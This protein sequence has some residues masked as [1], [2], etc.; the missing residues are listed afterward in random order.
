MRRAALLI[1]VALVSTLCAAQ[2]P[3]VRVRLLTQYRLSQI[4]ITPETNSTLTAGANSTTRLRA[5]VI[6]RARNNAVEMSGRVN[7]MVVVGG[8]FTLAS[9]PARSQTLHVP[10]E[11][12]ARAGSLQAVA[13]FPVEDYVASVLQGETAADMPPEALKALA[14][15]IRSYA[16]HF[17]GRHES[18]G[19]DFCDTT[20]CQYLRTEVAAR[21]RAAV[22]QTSGQLLWDRGTPLAAYYHKDCG[23]RTEA[24]GVAWPDQASAELSSQRDP[25]CIRT[26]AQWRAELSRADIERALTGAGLTVP[27][28]WTRIAVSDR[29]PSGRA[30]LLRFGSGSTQAGVP[31]SASS[32]RFALGRTL[33]WNMLKSD[34]YDV[35][36]SGDRFV[37]SGRGV[38]HGV[39]L[40]QTGASEMAREGRTYREILAFYYAGA[41]LGRSAQGIPW[42]TTRDTTF[43]LLVVNPADAAAVQRAARAALAW[44]EKQSG[45]ALTVHPNVEVYPSVAMFRDATGEPGWVAASTRGN[46]IRMQPPSVLGTRVEAVLRHEFLHMVVESNAKA[47]TPLWF[48]EGLVVYLTGGTHRAISGRLSPDQIE[49]TITSRRSQAEV[50]NAYAAAAEVVSELERHSGR[51][52]LIRWLHDGLPS[53]AVR[54]VGMQTAH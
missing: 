9:E 15:A 35:A 10:V 36:G 44:V 41:P 47:N 17:R 30:H 23:G 54:R 8:D 31:V 40:C 53:D 28:G 49:E 5:P 26:T 2:Q 52:E 6:V 25:Y 34:W 45:L 4:T 7:P 3:A 39:G 43:D 51:D 18:E 27:P 29:T 22:E 20:H 48:R 37:F 21:V 16:T 32:F 13:R 46:R 33:G 1:S 12:S 14:V 38:G 11:I 19:F 24:A 42:K 50:E